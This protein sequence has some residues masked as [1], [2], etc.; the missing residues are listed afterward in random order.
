MPRQAVLVGLAVFVALPSLAGADVLCIKTS[1]NTRMIRIRAG[2]QCRS[3]EVSIGTFDGTTLALTG[4]NL[5]VQS[6]DV[7]VDGGN[8]HVRSGSG[9]TYTDDPTGKGNVIIGYNEGSGDEVRNGDHNLVI[10]EENDYRGIG[11]I[12]HGYDNLVT[13]VYSAVIAG[14]QSSATGVSSLAA[15][16]DAGEAT[17]YKAAVVGGLFNEA[18]GPGAV[19]IGGEFNEAAG[20]LSTVTGGHTNRTASLWSSVVGGACNVA[21]GTAGPTCSTAAC[22]PGGCFETVTGGLMNGATGAYSTVSGGM[23]R[24]AAGANDWVA[25]SLFQDD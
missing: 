25:G 1:G 6:A 20:N 8:L 14:T 10:G 7:T 23:S 16:T 18:S 21:G 9:T 12:V 15:G 3:S 24:S 22:T 5:K 4:V 2:S 13:S 11:G 17:G 19:V